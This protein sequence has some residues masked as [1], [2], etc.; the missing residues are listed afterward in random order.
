MDI[1]LEHASGKGSLIKTEMKKKKR[2]KNRAGVVDV[3]VGIL[4]KSAD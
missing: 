3:S 2:K 4:Q 1:L